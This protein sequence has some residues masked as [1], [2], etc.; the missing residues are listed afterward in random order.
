MEE[1]E[2]ETGRGTMAKLSDGRVTNVEERGKYRVMKFADT[3][4]EKRCRIKS[5]GR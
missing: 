1:E 5:E 4:V 3:R 2:R